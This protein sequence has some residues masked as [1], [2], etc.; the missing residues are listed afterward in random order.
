VKEPSIRQQ[1]IAEQIL[2]ILS[3]IFT[4]GVSNPVLSGITVTDVTIDR[5][6]R[7]ADVYVTSTEGDEVRE[8]VMQALDKASGFLRS[9]VAAQMTIQHMP[10]LRFKWDETLEQAQRIDSIL[11]S[12]EI[13]GEEEQDDS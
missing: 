4:F 13:P 6:I 1:R 10:E 12:L 11:D 8:E 5:E 9:E 3:E 2:E 7:H